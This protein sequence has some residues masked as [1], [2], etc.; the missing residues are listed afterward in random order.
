[1]AST[2]LRHA[3]REAAYF[4]LLRAR[5]DVTTLQRH[6]EWLADEQRRMR[7]QVAENA[8]ADDATSRRLR[9]PLA[10]VDRSLDEAVKARLRVLAEEQAGLAERQQA[11]AEY[12]VECEAELAAHGG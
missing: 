6:E 1:M 3:D 7:R 12:V 9:R 4:A 2:G 8:A 10:A 11:A 5:E